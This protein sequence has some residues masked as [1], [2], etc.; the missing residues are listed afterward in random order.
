MS[1]KAFENAWDTIKMNPRLPKE[2][3]LDGV[4]SV[5]PNPPT[6]NAGM[7]RDPDL[8]ARLKRMY[9]DNPMKRKKDE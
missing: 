4:L 2:G 8:L 6:M 3:S 1:S 5:K 9:G 7:P